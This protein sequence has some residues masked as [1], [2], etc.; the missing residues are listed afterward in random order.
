[1]STG[2]E[3]QRRSPSSRSALPTTVIDATNAQDVDDLD[4]GQGFHWTLV[5]HPEEQQ[6]LHWIRTM[7]PPNALVQMEPTVRDRDTQR[8]VDGANAGA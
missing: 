7:T 5:L 2:C 8:P 1:M 4:A 6:A 3:P